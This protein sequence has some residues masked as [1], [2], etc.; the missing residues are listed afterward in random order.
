M[1][2][3]KSVKIRYL[4]GDNRKRIRYLLSVLNKLWKKHFYHLPMRHFWM[5]ELENAY[6]N[7]FQEMCGLLDANIILDEYYHLL[8][9][10]SLKNAFC[11]YHYYV[12]CLWR[13][14]NAAK[15]LPDE[16]LFNLR[17]KMSDLLIEEFDFLYDDYLRY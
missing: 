2:G 4:L 13:I 6:L 15:H 1:E 16:A 5:C 17:T 14:L 11:Q 7:V 9:K 12:N 10:E 8:P 3:E